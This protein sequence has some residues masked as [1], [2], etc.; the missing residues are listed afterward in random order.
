MAVAIYYDGD[1]PFC[2]RYVSYLRLKEAVGA[3]MLVDLRQDE[4]ARSRLSDA[5]YDVDQGMVAEIDG[6]FYHGDDAVH[7]L[8]LAAGPSGTLNRLTAGIFANPTVARIAYPVMRAGR[9]LTLDLLGRRPMAAE[10]AGLEAKFRLFALTFGFFTIFHS[11]G[12]VL[13]YGRYPPAPDIMLLF[14]LGIATVV[15]PASRLVFLMLIGGSLVSGWLQAPIE[16]NHSL[17]RNFTALGFVVVYGLNLLRGRPWTRTMADFSLVGGAALV[18]MYVF[19]IFHKIN[20]GFLDPAV[21]CAVELWTRMPEPLRSIRGDFVDYGTIYATF[22]VEGAILVA[23]FIP[24]VRHV[25]IVAGILFHLLLAL[26]SFSMYLPFTTLSISLHVLFLSPDAAGRV[27]ASPIMTA[28]TSR[29]T[30]PS[31]A[32]VWIVYVALI[33]GFGIAAEYTLSTLAAAVF[34]IPLCAAILVYGASGRHET[35]AGQR[36][37]LAGRA[38]AAAMGTLLFAACMAPYAG[39]KTGQS[40]S[41]F[42]NLR[43]EGGVSNHLVFRNPPSLFG[44]LDKVALITEASGS[45]VLDH[46]LRTGNGMVWYALL[47]T[48]RA[49]P[50]ATVSYRLDGVD[51]EAQSAATLAAEIER[52]LYPPVASKFLH[53][54]E[55]V[56]DTPPRCI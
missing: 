42:A 36:S 22:I 52:E 16:S 13:N 51:Y 28:F 40:I 47:D 29:L 56:M 14:V 34:V 24:R 7:A 25:A 38:V 4:A 49:T 5:G 6:R 44:N 21:S 30:R 35:V 31:W 1:C 45:R 23:L 39:L 11:I 37:S 12:Y 55:V 54:R 33:I 19:G 17:L 3:P 41:M 27:M 10:D 18:V 20:G 43:L 26:S 15:M 8:S 9:N 2:T 32:P 53:F 46:H 48:L 50:D